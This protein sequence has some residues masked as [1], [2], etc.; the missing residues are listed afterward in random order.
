MRVALCLLLATAAV[1]AAEKNKLSFVRDIV[2]ILTKSGCNSS[3]TLADFTGQIER[4][5]LSY[6]G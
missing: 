5:R 6:G 2:P 4:D 3:S 1:S